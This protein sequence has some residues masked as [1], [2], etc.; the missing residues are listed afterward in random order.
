ML[1]DGSDRWQRRRGLGRCKNTGT[2]D[3]LLLPAVTAV[4]F[5]PGSVPR[6]R[7]VGVL[8]LR[9][10]LFQDVATSF[11]LTV[12]AAA[13]RLEFDVAASLRSTPR[14]VSMWIHAHASVYGANFT[15]FPHDII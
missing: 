1:S 10:A 14:A 3:S 7:C 2:E 12:A 11:R 4:S 15:H 13:V 9:F 5:L 6:G 8:G